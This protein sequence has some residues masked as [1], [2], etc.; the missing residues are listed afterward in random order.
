MAKITINNKLPLY[1]P[2]P[3]LAVLAAAILFG[4]STPFAKQYAGHAVGRNSLF[5]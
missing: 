1:L 5:G 3:V 4:A 2:P